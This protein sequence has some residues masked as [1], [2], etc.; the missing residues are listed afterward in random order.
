MIRHRIRKKAFRRIVDAPNA[1]IPCPEHIQLKFQDLLAQ[2]KRWKDQH[3]NEETPTHIELCCIEA[4]SSP[5]TFDADSKHP[6]IALDRMDYS[7]EELDLILRHELSHLTLKHGNAL[8]GLRTFRGL[9]WFNPALI[10]IE[11]WCRQQFELLTD[12]DVL[13]QTNATPDQRVSYA[14]L[15]VDLAQE[16]QLHGVAQ[17]LS[18]GAK[19]ILQRT[20]EILRPHRRKLSLPVS[21]LLIAI[22]VFG[23]MVIA[24]GETLDSRFSTRQDLLACIGNR[25]KTVTRGLDPLRND[26]SYQPVYIDSQP[27]YIK[28][29]NDGSCRLY[30]FITTEAAAVESLALQYRKQHR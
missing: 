24:P 30:T 21:I 10:F 11:K 19:F 12:D 7:D 8:T 14:R 15:L 25:Y 27:V 1:R 3:E 6:V 18:A 22:T 23:T 29:N 20:E 4:F 5:C 2:D 9:Y 13:L 26:P 16:K 28:K 17:R